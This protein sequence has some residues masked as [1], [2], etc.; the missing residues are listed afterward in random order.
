MREQYIE[1][2]D[3]ETLLEGFLCYDESQPG[4]RLGRPR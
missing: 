2:R 4:L 3:G 1:Y